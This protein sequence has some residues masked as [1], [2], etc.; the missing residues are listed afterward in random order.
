M[1][2]ARVLEHL[3]G[4]L[5]VFVDSCEALGILPRHGPVPVAQVEQRLQISGPGLLDGVAPS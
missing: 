4:Q 1:A 3:R 2:P 5:V